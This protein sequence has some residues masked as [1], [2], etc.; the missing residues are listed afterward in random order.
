MRFSFLFI[1]M[2]YFLPNVLS[3]LLCNLKDVLF[4]CPRR[5]EL[6]LDDAKHLWLLKTTRETWA[7]QYYTQLNGIL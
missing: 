6:L 4:M 5:D 2:N 3:Q 1:V 7:C